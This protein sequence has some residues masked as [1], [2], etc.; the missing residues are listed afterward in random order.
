MKNG[1]L[2]SKGASCALAA[3]A[4]FGASTPFAKKLLRQID[5]WRMAGV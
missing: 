5:P 1:S 2:Q 4:L 3:A